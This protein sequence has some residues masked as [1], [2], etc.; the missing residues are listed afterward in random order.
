MIKYL[1]IF[2]AITSFNN[3]T[4]KK[5]YTF[6][7]QK[8]INEWQIVNDGVMGG[9]SKSTL[10]LSDGGYGKFSGHIALENNGGFASIQLNTRI[11]LEE[12]KKQRLEE[13]ETRE[14]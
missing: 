9:L 14:N 2:M 12:D 13:E 6:V 3:S 10:L 4:M 8:N 7:S 5:I 1:L 11:K